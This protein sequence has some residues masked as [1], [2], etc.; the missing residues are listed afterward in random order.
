MNITR[1][2]FLN[3]GGK[4]LTAAV[5]SLGRENIKKGQEWTLEFRV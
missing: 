2:R 4:G 1:R 5:F 3:E